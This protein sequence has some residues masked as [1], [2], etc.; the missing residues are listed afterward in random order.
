[1]RKINKPNISQAEVCNSFKELEYRERI[2]KKSEEYNEKY[3]QVTDMLKEEEDFVA[4]NKEFS[5]YM[6][7]IYSER[8]SNK[9]YDKPYA[10]YKQIRE[11]ETKCPYCN[12]ITRTVKHLDHYYP[13]SKFPTLAITVNN[14]VPIC[15]EC[16][17]VKH[18]YYAKN[19]SELLIHPYYDEIV[20]DVFKFLKCR[21]I[22]DIKIG[23]EFYIEKLPQWEDIT[24]E[25]VKLHFKKLEIDDL[26]RSDFEADFV[27]CFEELLDLHKEKK[28]IEEIRVAIDRRVKALFKTQIKPWAYAGFKSILDSEWFFE[29]YLPMNCI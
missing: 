28:E 19:E 26:Y 21:V 8:F 23:F 24:F 27:S 29:I 20:R 3:L 18:E 2:L 10:Y 9:G 13:K 15:R 22:E 11:A 4:H 12:Y 6:K 7:K 5:S 17:D 14:L 16:N 25:R 1:M